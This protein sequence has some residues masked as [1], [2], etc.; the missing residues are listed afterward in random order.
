MRWSSPCSILSASAHSLF[1]SGRISQRPRAQGT[2]T[3]GKRKQGASLHPDPKAGPE[4]VKE[5][6]G[7]PTSLLWSTL[8][9]GEQSGG[10]NTEMQ[11]SLKDSLEG[12]PPRPPL[13]K[14]VWLAK[15]T[16]GKKGACLR[17]RGSR[18]TKASGK[19][20]LQHSGRQHLCCNHSAWPRQ[21]SAEGLL[22]QQMSK[23]T[24]VYCVP[25]VCLALC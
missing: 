23:G 2:V 12:G 22:Q 8:E 18:A 20:P 1:L 13:L 4:A 9:P 19:Q 3:L 21:T 15:D 16:Q 6:P 24:R 10:Q 14:S 7:K 11:A 5:A 17:S 25:S